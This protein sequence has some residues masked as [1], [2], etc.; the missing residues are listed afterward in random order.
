MDDWSSWSM[1]TVLKTVVQKCTVGSN[2][3]SSAMLCPPIPIGRGVRLRTG[4]VW[5]RIP[6]RAPILFFCVSTR[7]L[8]MPW[9][10]SR[11]HWLWPNGRVH[12]FQAFLSGGGLTR[13]ALNGKCAIKMLEPSLRIATC[14]KGGRSAAPNPK[15]PDANGTMLEVTGQH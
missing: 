7:G 5:V 15:A 13:A 10:L 8:Q 9:N 3:T 12:E 11:A 14:L 4:S 6:W 1:T 2:P